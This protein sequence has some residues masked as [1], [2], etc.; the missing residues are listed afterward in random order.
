MNSNHNSGKPSLF[1][2]DVLFIGAVYYYKR[3]NQITTTAVC[4]KGMCFRCLTQYCYY[5]SGTV[6]GSSESV[7]EIHKIY[8]RKMCTFLNCNNI[9]VKYTYSNAGL[10]FINYFSSCLPNK[11]VHVCLQSVRHAK[12]LMSIHVNSESSSDV[13][14]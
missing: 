9:F 13:R 2:Q 14:Y 1:L 12:V 11:G 6:V 8:I 5:L 7:L 10:C 4:P 3:R